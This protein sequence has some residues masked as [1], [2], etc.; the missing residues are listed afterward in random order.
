M[1]DLVKTTRH[2]C[3]NMFANDIAMYVTTSN[4]SL[5][6]THLN[7]DLS[8]IFNWVTSNGFRVNV[9][10]SQTLLIAIRHCK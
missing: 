5:I 3:I 8:A 1:N 6:Q 9:S 10:K 4:S 2:S 7:Y